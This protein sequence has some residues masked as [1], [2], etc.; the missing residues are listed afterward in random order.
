MGIGKLVNQPCF[1][2]SGKKFKKCCKNK[3]EEIKRALQFVN[4]ETGKIH[5]QIGGETFEEG[6]M[7]A[8]TPNSRGELVP[9]CIDHKK[10]LEEKAKKNRELRSQ[11]LK[12]HYVKS[13]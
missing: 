9:V 1:C 13:I 8:W 10:S 4:R 6:M 2:G 12:K 5:C 3:Q 11:R 7:I